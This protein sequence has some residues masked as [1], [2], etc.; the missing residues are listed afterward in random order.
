MEKA[1]RAKVVE[2]WS[3]RKVLE[4]PESKERDVQIDL[5]L[6][7]Q[8]LLIPAWLVNMQAVEDG[9]RELITT[10]AKDTAK[11]HIN[12]KQSLENISGT[13]NKLDLQKLQ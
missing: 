7:E 10:T 6:T 5:G 12:G 13:G 11:Y 8:R 4:S 3:M 1:D 9:I 2:P